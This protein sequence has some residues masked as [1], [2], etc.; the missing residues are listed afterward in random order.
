MSS[1]LDVLLIEDNPGD[2]RLIEE[3]LGTSAMRVRSE[4]GGN[5]VIAEAEARLHRADRLADGIEQLGERDP[6]AVLLD[7]GLPDS[8]GIGT[9]SRLL[10]ET[11]FL[12]IVVLTGL[13]DE[14]IGVEAIH[15]GAQ[16]YLVKDEVTEELLVRTLYHAIERSRQERDRERRRRQL[17]SLNRLNRV[18]Q[19]VTHAVIT[20]T[21]RGDLERTVCERLVAAEGYRFVWI[22]DS[23]RRSE[24]IDVRVGAGEDEAFY[25]ALRSPDGSGTAAR[26][27]QRAQETGDPQVIQDLANEADPSGWRKAALD[28]GLHAAAAIPIVYQEFSH[29]VLHIYAETPEAFTGPAIEVLE[30]LGDVIGHAITALE[31]KDALLNETVLEIE[32]AVDGVIDELVTLTGETDAS[33]TFENIVLEEHVIAYGVASGVA[34]AALRDRVEASSAIDD[35]RFL[36]EQ[37]AWCKFELLIDAIRPLTEA[38]TSHGGT[39]STADV[40]DGEFRFTVEF[41]TGRDKRQLIELVE[42]HCNGAIYQAHRTVDRA[43]DGI[44]QARSVLEEDLTPKQRSVLEAAYHAGFFEWPRQSNGQELADRL[45]ISPA[46]FSQHIRSAEQ[47]IFDGILTE[48]ERRIDREQAERTT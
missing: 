14:D 43:E 27:G 22:G 11:E 37:E 10:E 48:E 18:G 33:V 7:L 41:P 45:D 28:R 17:E 4:D 42:E 25:D 35:L 15:R 44:A 26:P 32:F 47:K 9:L 34:P 40:R 13:A 36:V 8:T 39:I 5:P 2:A 16:D 20:T 31:R 23:N 1:V 30:R 29:G 38:L 19:D 21:S 24:R 6:D 12:P 3:M 46:T